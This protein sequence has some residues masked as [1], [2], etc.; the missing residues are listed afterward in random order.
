MQ[1]WTSIGEREG[2]DSQEG[3][4]KHRHKTVGILWNRC[5]EH[6]CIWIYI[7][8]LNCGYITIRRGFFPTLL[9]NFVKLY[10]PPSLFGPKKKEAKTP[11]TAF[12][13]FLM[14]IIIFKS[15]N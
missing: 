14:A 13:I 11:L 6:D 12:Q 1:I 10:N 5:D 2:E 7:V 8:Y 15:D 9:R 3:S 4:E